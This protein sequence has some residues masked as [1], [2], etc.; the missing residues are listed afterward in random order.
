MCWIPQIIKF[1][2]FSFCFFLLIIIGA[3]C[4]KGLYLY[5]GQNSTDISLVIMN[6]DF[7]VPD[8]TFWLIGIGFGII[9]F[10]FFALLYCICNYAMKLCE[11]CCCHESQIATKKDVYSIMALLPTHV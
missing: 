4:G 10:V 2:C 1:I 6:P 7:Y 8:Q 5:S 9:V 11:D 3:Y